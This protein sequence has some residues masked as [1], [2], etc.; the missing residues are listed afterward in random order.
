MTSSPS[1]VTE[2]GNV[3]YQL[4]GYDPSGLGA[5]PGTGQIV[6][7][8]KL[9]RWK[10][11]KQIWQGT[12]H[13]NAEIPMHIVDPTTMPCLLTNAD[14]ELIGIDTVPLKRDAPLNCDGTI[15]QRDDGKPMMRHAYAD[16]SITPKSAY[17]IH[18]R[19][20]TLP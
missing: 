15:H 1:I 20:A 7:Q 14:A 18:H 4:E 11:I 2:P 17:H 9:S 19:Y 3:P 6:P 5:L 13:S 12:I 16:P 10:K 8:W